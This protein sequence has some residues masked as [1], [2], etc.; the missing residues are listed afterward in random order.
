MFKLPGL[1]EIVDCVDIVSGESKQIQKAIT[2]ILLVKL[3]N[4]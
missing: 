4:L 3:P 1:V 2:L